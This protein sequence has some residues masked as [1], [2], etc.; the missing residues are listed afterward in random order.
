MTT[1]QKSITPA[2]SALVVFIKAPE[3]GTVKTRLAGRLGDAAALALYQCFVA[4][5]LAMA[6]KTGRATR[7]YYHPARAGNRVRSWLGGGL[8][9]FPQTGDTLG[10]KMKNALAETFAAGFTRAVVMGS[11]LPDLPPEI[12]DE[13]FGRL[14]D[15]PAVMGPSRDG[16][17]Y[18]IGFTAGGF[19]PAV[20]DNIPW[21]TETVFK[22][23]L[24]RFRDQGIAP[25]ILPVWRDIDTIED[26][27]D[28]VLTLKEFPAPA[29]HTRAYLEEEYGQ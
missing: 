23:T 15:M 4:D 25:A 17:Y 22:K 3:P 14:I 7:V 26:L 10:E 13:A 11:D 19:A 9:I 2:R 29:K 28:L 21:G 5:I 24:Q 27:D 8:D 18:L 20:F 1:N 6:R 12:I 16:G